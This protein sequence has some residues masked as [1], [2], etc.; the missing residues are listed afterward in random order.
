MFALYLFT[1]KHLFTLFIVF[2]SLNIQ[3]QKVYKTPSGEKYHTAVCKSVK[4][5]SEEIALSEAKKI[6]LTP[7]EICKPNNENLNFVSNPNSSLGIKSNEAKGQNS[8]ATQCKGITKKGNR[9]K[10]KTKNKN[11]YC[12]QHE[13]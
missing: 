5:V 7:C 6:G 1:M 13:P 3:A 10:N 9:C 11:G 8:V 12:F 4:N 2:L